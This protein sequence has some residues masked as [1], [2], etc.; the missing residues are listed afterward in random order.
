M[1]SRYL[2]LALPLGLLACD[3]ISEDQC[4]FGDW[5]GIGLEDG[6]KGRPASIL[7][8]YTEICGALGISPERSIYLAARQEG[9][10]TYCTPRTAYEVG[11]RGNK[12]S[13]V[14]TGEQ[15]NAMLPAYDRGL[16]YF[17]IDEIID[18]LR[19]EVNQLR[20]I[21]GSFPP[22]PDAEQQAE[23]ERIK[24]KID[25]LKDRVSDLGRDQRRYSSWQ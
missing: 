5:T 1:M 10:K 18:D 7:Q 21:L 16:A 2:L 19:D 13:P 4:R 12:L 24:D 20:S 3:P 17:E 22:A 6:Q 25:D 9:L 15:V 8:E 11:R 14:C 23:I